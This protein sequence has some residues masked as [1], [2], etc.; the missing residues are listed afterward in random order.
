[1]TNSVAAQEITA[2]N[3]NGNVIGKVIPDGKVVGF[4]NSLVGNITADSFVIDFDG[5]LIGGIVPQGIAIGNDSKPLG[6]VGNDGSVRMASGQVVGRVLPSGLVVNDYYDIIGGVV[7]PGL[8]YSDR[9]ETVGRITGDG[10]FTN[11]AGQRIGIV[12]P[13][14]YAYQKVE[15]E[16]LLVGRLISSKMVVSLQGDFIG[17]VAPGGKVSDFDSKVI[18]N[19]KA[20][21]YVYNEDNRI[22]GH[23]VR[24]GYAF[25]NNGSYM[26]VISYN[27]EVVRKG[28]TVGHIRADGNIIDADNK[29]VG[30]GLDI[31]TTFTDLK[32]R[33]LGRIMPEGKVYRSAEVLAQVGARGVV[34]GSDG[35]IIGQAV[36]S[37][38]VFDYKGALKGH[39]LSNG[40]V[41]ALSGT[42]IGYM[43]GESAYDLS[44]RMIGAVLHEQAAFGLDNAYLGVSGI[45]SQIFAE[46]AFVSPLGYVFNQE[47]EIYGN[48]LRLS[49]LYSPNGFSIAL[50]GV[51]GQAVNVNGSVLGS[52]TGGGYVLTPQNKLIGKNINDLFITA[53]DGSFLGNLTA[54]NLVLNSSL[55]IVAKILPD[56]SVVKTSDADTVNYMPKLGSSWSGRVVTD[57]AGDFLGYTDILGNLNNLN[58]AKT[59]AVVDRGVA[60]DNNG[61]LIG[62]LQD[63]GT[64][65][66]E[67]CEFIG[68]LTPRGDVQNYR[69]TYI[70][71]VLGNKYV[72][73]DNGISV[74]YI[75]RTAPVI[76]YSGKIIGFIG[77]NG[78]VT[79]FDGSILGCIDRKG[80]LYNA[81]KSLIG[82]TVSYSTAMNFNSEII[83][84][85][86]L[87]GGI[88]NEDNQIIAYQQPDGNVNS[89]SGLP[90][91]HIFK[92]KFAF[93]LDNHLLGRILENGTI[94][95]DKNSVIGRVDFDGFV[96]IDNQQ[97]GYALYDLYVYD[98][99][100]NVIGYINRNG[101]VLNFTGKNIGRIDRGFLLDKSNMVIG[102]GAR[103]YTI[104]DKS[105]LVIGRLLLSGD[106]QDKDGKLIGKLDK[107]G[108]IKNQNQEIIAIATPL[109]YYSKIAS[110]PK[111]QMVFDKDG[112][113]IGYLDENGNLVDK[114]GNIIRRYDEKDGEELG[115]RPVFDKQGEI[116][117]VADAEGVVKNIDGK[118][119]GQLNEDGDLVDA[120]GNIIGG[121]NRNW[122][123][124]A[125]L[126]AEIRKDEDVSPALKL[127]ES[128]N[129]KK[130]LGVALTPDGEYL[131]QIMEDKT[132]VDDDDN[133]VGYLMP[134]GLVIDEDG[135]LIGLEETHQP[136]G[137]GMFVP[138]GTFGDG[139]AYGTGAGSPGNLG[140]GGGFGP[141]E[142]YDPARQAALEAAMSERRK[143]ISVGKISNGVRKEAFD[144]MQKD[145]AEQGIGKVISS[146][147]VDMSEMILSDK[148]IP[149]V[150]ARAIDSNNPAPI[151]AFVERNVYAEEGRNII[152]PAGS[153]LIGSLGGVTASA[154]ATSEAARVQI[155]W[156]RLI[157]PD[158]SI[159]VFQGLT[160]DAQ[161]R[162]GALGY[163]DQQLFKKYT[164][165][166][167][168]SSLTSFTSY[169]MAPT[170]NSGSE[171]E[172]PRQQAANDARQNFIN[173]M[174][175]IFDEILA[176]KSN[177]KALTY[178]PAGT[179]IIVFPNTDLWLRTVERDQDSSL[180]LNKPEILIDD[181][182][183]AAERENA[184]RAATSEVPV[185]GDVVYDAGVEDI[186]SSGS[187]RP[188]IADTNKKAET[189]KGAIVPP[190]PPPSSSVG[191][192][193]AG[194]AE[195]T[196]TTSDSS[197]PAL[198]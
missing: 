87:D 152:I 165:P 71:R 18:G 17:S 47:G 35:T 180:Q 190:P 74:G 15:D 159:F 133:V 176:D 62:I 196:G 66:N 1:M 19:I 10:L 171:T 154:E 195:T 194:G 52:L 80:A 175:T 11:L 59:G 127:L 146:W 2:I 185:G 144:G 119:L 167:L 75:V 107:A 49:Q 4:D 123:E 65:I 110:A 105:R 128:S 178:V 44:G 148:P 145:W 189:N 40:A 101:E 93:D 31:G 168:T 33:Y 92:Y 131:G 137:S 188:L 43:V 135:T 170:E 197:V 129:Y 29:V 163:V 24:S 83:G 91:G 69:G 6:K 130:S 90:I 117:G 122:Y 121:I 99:D 68:V 95:N 86:V 77:S 198:F 136:D 98:Q 26:G 158:G 160:A 37:G 16:Y 12:T 103:D 54:S 73:S 113:F 41:I 97:A 124:K 162:G 45:N 82:S 100:D 14:G 192:V 173:E 161:G 181:A 36:V 108:E 42:T 51:D 182:K 88:V 53:A 149:A 48:S 143:N 157:R 114:D 150:I 151:T 191:N 156:E 85:S 9:G 193:T 134:D 27:G 187:S 20:N 25:D 8:V 89:D 183:V 28:K 153:R 30:Y 64:V 172:T 72:I 125:P 21:G 184:N 22:I 55:N 94:I 39:A 166:V 84:R 104:R 142:R 155:S 56:N 109:Q 120:N 61:L 177:I 138:P 141:G 23:V 102:R 116:I 38:P 140:P 115:E 174:N 106:V 139:G 126:P 81:D 118:I 3:F 78:K 147:R 70:G 111:R 13:D 34:M 63:Y 50:L 57:F 186:E 112:N 132:V 7:F 32:G 60:I 76:D 169:L 79:G 67:N 58:K 164:L 46:S 179:R 96:L 5:N